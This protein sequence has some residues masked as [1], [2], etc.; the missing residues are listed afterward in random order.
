MN[1]QRDPRV[2]ELT[3]ML[4][5][6]YPPRRQ[7]TLE[8]VDGSIGND[9]MGRYYYPRCHIT[10]SS[11]YNR[12]VEVAIH[13]YAHHIHQTEDPCNSMEEAHGREFKEIYTILMDLY[14]AMY[15]PFQQPDGRFYLGK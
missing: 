7:F 5:T 13:E 14:N 10:I 3:K 8:I 6:I 4:T 15:A 2:S 11:C 12:N 1:I 9:I